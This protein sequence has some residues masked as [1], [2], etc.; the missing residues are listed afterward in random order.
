M[1]ANEEYTQFVDEQLKRATPLETKPMAVTPAGLKGIDVRDKQ[2]RSSQMP[3]GVF[4]AEC[5][6]TG[7]KADFALLH[8]GCF[9]GDDCFKPVL[10]QQLLGDVF[11][12]DDPPSIIVAELERSQLDAILEHGKRKLRD[13]AYPQY[14]PSLPPELHRLKVAIPWFI[15]DDDGDGYRTV[16]KNSATW[17]DDQINEKLEGWTKT[18]WSIIDLVTSEHKNHMSLLDDAGAAKSEPLP[19][20]A[21]KSFIVAC[22]DLRKYFGPNAQTV[23]TKTSNAIRSQSNEGSVFWRNCSI[24]RVN[25]SLDRINQSKRSRGFCSR[26]AH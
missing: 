9:R 16:L 15:L 20:D 17:T 2:I 18:N 19:D 3:F 4:V 5:V 25:H 22:G 1:Q 11:I 10:N 23:H 26:C 14:S 7:T 8:S 6:R 12:F 24:I 13:G 21:I